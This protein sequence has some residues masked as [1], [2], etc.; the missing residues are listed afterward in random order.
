MEGTKL[1]YLLT[2]GPSPFTWALLARSHL[3]WG[4]SP[5]SPVSGCLRKV[6]LVKEITGAKV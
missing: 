3:A 5:V 1:P 2:V 4:V 6:I